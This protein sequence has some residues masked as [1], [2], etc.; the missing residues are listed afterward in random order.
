MNEDKQVEISQEEFDALFFT[1]KQFGEV[2]AGKNSPHPVK[3]TVAKTLVKKGMLIE[4]HKP[5][6]K[7]TWYIFKLTE[8]GHKFLIKRADEELEKER[9]RDENDPNVIT[10]SKI[11]KKVND[12]SIT[13]SEFDEYS[14][15]VFQAIK[16]KYVKA[17][18]IPHTNFVIFKDAYN[19][20]LKIN[21]ERRNAIIDIM[22]K[23]A[24][25][26]ISV[27]D[28]H[29]KL[30]E[31]GMCLEFCAMFLQL[32]RDSIQLKEIMEKMAMTIDDND[33]ENVNKI[34]KSKL[35]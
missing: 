17:E 4:T 26:S 10:R 25:G 15:F 16:E 8:K 33:F 2:K 32:M 22:S 34:D 20:P 28:F 24:G 6:T 14:D 23:Y 35:N 3:L 27:V 7:R 21:H 5:A 12:G 18:V 13:L 1:L 30:F 9:I 31:I 29:E 19:V 11:R